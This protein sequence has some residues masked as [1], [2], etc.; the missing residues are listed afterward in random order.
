MSDQRFLFFGA[1][2]AGTGIANLIAAA[3]AEQGL[4]EAEARQRCWFVD[5]K[6]LVV[7]SRNDL[8]EYKRPFAHDHEF[9][10]DGV[11]IIETIR[12]TALIGTAGTPGAF[13]RPMLESAARINARPIVFALSNPTSM[14]ECTAEQAYGWTDGRAVFASGSPFDP[15]TMGGKRFV[16]AQGNNAYI[17]PG[18]GL[19]VITAGSRLVTDEMFLAAAHALANQV[20]QADLD[21]G[22]VY[23]S[24]R[25][26]RDV[27]ASVAVAVV[28]IAQRQKLATRAVPDDLYSQIRSM[29][30]E[31]EYVSYSVG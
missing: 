21:Q 7:N 2:E 1:G 18:I 30:F 15:V 26:I 13:S 19:G 4:P 12:P 14:A 16:P 20:S 22:S 6:G 9:L 5:S 8:A 25:T 29:M 24:L 27:S 11:A 17:F 31:P 10:S 28:E 23:P 3:M